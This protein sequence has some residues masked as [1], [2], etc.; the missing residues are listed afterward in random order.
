MIG[1]RGLVV[2]ACLM[3]PA[4]EYFPE[5]SFTLSPD[6][7]LPRWFELPEGVSR[8]DVSVTM[9]YYV[10]P[11][12]R[13]ARLVLRDTRKIR[14]LAQ[15]EG[16]LF[17]HE[18]LTLHNSPEGHPKGYPSYEVIDVNGIVEIVEHRR[19]EPVFYI[20]DDPAVHSELL[21]RTAVIDG[22]RR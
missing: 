3:A 20:S 11:S 15:V 6:S 16:R 5:A 8:S 19:R 4:C 21:G 9:S 22:R 1:V 17:G 18:P 12:G 2:I 7:R 13:Y 14:K 10:Y